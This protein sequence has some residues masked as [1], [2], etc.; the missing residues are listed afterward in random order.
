MNKKTVGKL[1][2]LGE[3]SGI[4]QWSK[5]MILVKHKNATIN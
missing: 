1:K 2:K 5:K 4:Q 3:C